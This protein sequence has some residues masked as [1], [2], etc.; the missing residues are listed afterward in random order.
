MEFLKGKKIAFLITLFSALM[1]IFGVLTREYTNSPYVN[2]RYESKNSLLKWYEVNVF[3]M[4]FD[5]V[6]FLLFFIIT[7]GLGIY[8]MVYS[9]DQT[10]KDKFKKLTIFNKI[11]SKFSESKKNIESKKDLN[12]NDQTPENK[13][14]KP[15]LFDKV[16]TRFSKL[17][18]KRVPNK[19]IALEDLNQ[20]NE[21]ITNVRNITWMALL[22]TGYMAFQ[23]GFSLWFFIILPYYYFIKL[24]PKSKIVLVLKS[25]GYPLI[26]L[27]GFAL[28]EE[29]INNSSSNN[30][31]DYGLA[32]YFAKHF[33]GFIF[34]FITILISQLIRYNKP[35][36]FSLKNPLFWLA[37]LS[38]IFSIYVFTVHKQ[39]EAILE[40][41][42]GY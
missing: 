19:A 17:K 25:I 36:K 7:L 41:I 26:F 1:L 11:N 6:N 39:N 2:G 32:Y 27:I 30:L 22:F 15:N 35:P 4:S 33:L 8:L 31:F 38:L 34:S 21:I 5:Y 12:H 20:N 23:I 14:K 29:G 40:K 16:K 10:L 37:L 18:K 24:I 13:E 42:R 28:N 3:G 9:N